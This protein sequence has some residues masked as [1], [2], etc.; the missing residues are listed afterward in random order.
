MKGVDRYNKDI[1]NYNPGP[2]AAPGTYSAENFLENFRDLLA[3]TKTSQTEAARK[4]GAT[5]TAVN[6]WCAGLFLPDLTN[7]C[8]ICDAFGV[9]PEWLLAKHVKIKKERT[10]HEDEEA[11]TT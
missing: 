11:I 9:L 5:P 6:K 2:Y 7:L 3:S 1:G 8:G 4:I 10:R